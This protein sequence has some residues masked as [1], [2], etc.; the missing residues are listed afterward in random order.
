MNENLQRLSLCMIVKNEEETLPRCLKSVCSL[1]DEIIIVDTGS[2]DL[3]LSVAKDFCAQIFSFAWDDNF[4]SARNYSL[5]QASGDWILVL[6]ADLQL[7][8]YL[9][10][11]K[12]RTVIAPLRL[13]TWQEQ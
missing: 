8:Q 12:L 13:C 10:G 4:S 9:T 6:D 7:F 2:T 11:N 1:V 5:D 3:T